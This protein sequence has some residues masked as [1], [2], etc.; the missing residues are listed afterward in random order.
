[1]AEQA[2]RKFGFGGMLTG[3]LAGGRRACGGDDAGA[4]CTG[5][6]GAVFLAG[7]GAGGAV[8]TGAGATALTVVVVVVGAVVGG[9]VVVGAG[10]RPLDGGAATPLPTVFAA[11]AVVLAGAWFDALGRAIT[12]TSA[13]SSATS[14]HD[15]TRNHAP[16]VRAP[17]FPSPSPSS[18]I[19][20]ASARRALHLRDQRGDH[21]PSPED[22]HSRDDQPQIIPSV[23]LTSRC[24]H[25]DIEAVTPH[26]ASIR[27]IRAAPSFWRFWKYRDRFEACLA[28]RSALLPALILA[29]AADIFP[30]RVNRL[31][32]ARS[33]VPIRFS[34]FE[35]RPQSI[36]WWGFTIAQIWLAAR[37][38]FLTLAGVDAVGE[39][40]VVVGPVVVGPDVVE[41]VDAALAT[42]ARPKMS[43]IP[44]RLPAARFLIFF[45]F[46]PLPVVWN[47]KRPE[48]LH[49]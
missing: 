2:A 41:V 47:A 42:P 24:R 37:V 10:R 25:H 43:A 31:L 22:E 26:L 23:M 4:V 20:G 30:H 45:I 40:V 19:R 38:P 15:A 27:L 5:G 7:A 12:A 48:T 6:G 3:G 46:R 35:E 44:T 32:A 28:S 8:V 9:V 29:A 16:R 14:I 13:T 36:L 1:V 33:A 18:R 34:S 39:V 17:L 49:P 21:P 11:S